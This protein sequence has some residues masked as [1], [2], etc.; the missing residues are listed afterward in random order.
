M[1]P[2]PKI[3]YHLY[4]LC[5]VIRRAS[6]V[7]GINVRVSL[8]FSVGEFTLGILVIVIVVLQQSLLL[9]L[10]FVVEFQKVV[11]EYNG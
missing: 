10:L 3:I 5:F 6:T 4:V 1:F 7:S 8:F 9:L 11:L 2:P